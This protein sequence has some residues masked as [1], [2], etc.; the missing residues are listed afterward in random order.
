MY[1]AVIGMVVN[2]VVTL[3][4]VGGVVI[5]VVEAMGSEKELGWMGWLECVVG[6]RQK[7]YLLPKV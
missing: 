3:V 5:V 6:F 1:V 7:R 4:V 2:R